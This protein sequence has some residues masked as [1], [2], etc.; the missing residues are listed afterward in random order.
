MNKTRSTVAQIKIGNRAREC[1]CRTGFTRG[2]IFE[3]HLKIVQALRRLQFERIS[4]CER[5]CVHVV[6]FFLNSSILQ[7]IIQLL[8]VQQHH[9]R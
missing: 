6:K 7:T 2:V 5:S 1:G 3:N 9:D 8:Y 4:K